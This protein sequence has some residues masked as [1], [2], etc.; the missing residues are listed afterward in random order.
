MRPIEV[1]GIVNEQSRYTVGETM[2]RIESLIWSRGMMVLARFDN[3]LAAKQHCFDAHPM[4]T[5]IFGDVRLEAPLLKACPSLA[6][7]LPFKVV[8]W[9]A[10][11][12]EVWVSYNSLDYLHT[13]HGLPA[14]PFPEMDTMILRALC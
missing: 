8:V 11:P 6:L 13:R 3:Q 2:D 9:E 10:A 4:Q 5:L 14:I 7:D 1:N 12:G